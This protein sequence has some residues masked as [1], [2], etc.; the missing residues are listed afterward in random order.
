MNTQGKSNSEFWLD[1][2]WKITIILM[3]ASIMSSLISLKS[4]L[5]AREQLLESTQEHRLPSQ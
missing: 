2:V 1:V 3:Y 4:D 5:R